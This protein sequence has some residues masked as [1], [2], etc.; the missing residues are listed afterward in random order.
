M[1]GRSRAD[2]PQDRACTLVVLVVQDPGE[3]V[4][5]ARGYRLE[6]VADDEADPV[7]QRGLVPVGLGQVEDD[8][9]HLRLQLEQGSKQRAVPAADVDDCLAGTPAQTG[10]AAG[11][12][13]FV[14]GHRRVEGDPFGRIR[15]EPRPEVRA[16][17]AWKGWLGGPWIER[18]G[19]LEEDRAEQVREFPPAVA[20]QELRRVG[21]AEDTGLVL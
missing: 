13:S 21:V 1:L 16:E 11:L 12:V 5:I 14:A 7:A 9:P 8:A 2:L 3:H 6:E 20:A 15:L 10:E 18:R 17:L 4:R 19:G